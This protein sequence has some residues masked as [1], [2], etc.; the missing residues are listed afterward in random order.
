[1]LVDDMKIDFL[2]KG[3]KTKEEKADDNR[4]VKLVPDGYNSWR[5]VYAD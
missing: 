4:P 1:M 3:R 5:V 2:N